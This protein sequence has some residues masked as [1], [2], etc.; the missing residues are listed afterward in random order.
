MVRAGDQTW[1][2]TSGDLARLLTVDLT[3]GQVLVDEKALADWLAARAAA[4]DRPAVEAR[5]VVGETVALQPG[6][7][8]RQIDRPAALQ[9]LRSALRGEAGEISLP[10]QTLSPPVTAAMLQAAFDRARQLTAGDLR[11]TYGDR[12]WTLPRAALLAAL[13]ITGSGPATQVGL[14]R[15]ALAERLAPIRQ[16]IDQPARDAR[17]RFQN[18]RVEVVAPEQEGRSVDVAATVEQI[19]RALLAG[20]TEVPLVVRA[21]SSRSTRHWDRPPLTPATRSAG[22]SRWPTRRCG[23]SPRWPEGSARWPRRS[24]TP[25]SGPGWRSSSAT[26][27]CTGSRATGCRPGG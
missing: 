9:A 7:T 17:F 2:L 3:T 14:K 25:S 12:S 19:E 16:A 18:G 11:L 20:R 5:L 22:G 24:S 10:V 6:Q 8:G 26:R 21:A 23:R 1:T 27:T 4:F 15:E 13:Q